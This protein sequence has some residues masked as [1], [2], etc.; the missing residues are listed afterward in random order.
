MGF[1]H[2]LCVWRAIKL[3]AESHDVLAKRTNF[4]T[5]PSKAQEMFRFE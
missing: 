2:E 5:A 1:R 4:W 3:V